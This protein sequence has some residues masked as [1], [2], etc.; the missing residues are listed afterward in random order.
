MEEE[1]D[2]P[3]WSLDQVRETFMRPLVAKDSRP[4]TGWQMAGRDSR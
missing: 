1:I 4:G 3:G 2:M